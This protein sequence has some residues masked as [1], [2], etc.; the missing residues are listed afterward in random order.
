MSASGARAADRP[1]L[2][3]ILPVHN[4]GD[5]VADVVTSYETVLAR[6]GRSYELLLVTNAC[7]DRSVNICAGL[8]RENPCVEHIDLPQGG[9]GRAVR[10]GLRACS[11]EMICYTNLARTSAPTLGLLLAYNLAFP[12][13]VVKASR[14]VRDNWK[15]RLGSL[16][17]NLECRALFDVAVWDVNGTPKVFP[18]S[19]G[20]LM[21]VSRDDDLI[22]AEFVAICRREGYPVVDV[23]VIFTG[24]HGGRSTTRYSSAVRMYL[25]ALSL[26]RALRAT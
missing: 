10:A 1:E 11:G 14:K 4:D 21:A 13:V 15:R 17:Y 25:G 6:L 9:W 18:R 3:I 26:Y 20:R 22:D 23:P 19:F 24:R 12:D 7:T 8:A 2:S 5:Y 16:I